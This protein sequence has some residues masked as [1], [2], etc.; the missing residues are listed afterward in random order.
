MARINLLPWR[1]EERQRKNKEFNVLAGA[2]AALSVLAI[3]LAMTFLGN[4]LSNQ[5]AAND[6]VK[7][8][9]ARLDGVLTQI[10]DLEKQR[11]DM[12]ARMKVIQDLQGHRSVPVRVWDDIARALPGNA[13]LVGMKR[14]GDM[15][16][17]TGY[18]A[19]PNVVSE[20]VRNLDASPWLASSG[21]PNVKTS[22]EAYATPSSLNQTK[23]GDLPR[24]VL[25]EDSYISFTVTTKVV[26]EGFGSE[27]T[28]DPSTNL[29]VA[30]PEGISEA[31]PMVVAPDQTQPTDTTQSD[32]NA[33]APQTQP[34]A[35]A[36]QTQPVVV[37]TQAQAA[38]AQVPP[39][40]VAPVKVEQ[41]ATTTV[42]GQAS[43]QSVGGQ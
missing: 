21:V 39:A 33:V 29:T 6:K 40:Q 27:A 17:L 5:Q 18:A 31:Q 23:E 36:P 37:E 16:T 12:L 19:D 32:Q 8:E 14:E 22:V 2:A 20:L 24:I 9:V 28:A 30:A 7:A 42:P 10:D 38:P 4:E 41:P 43:T 13:Y 26:T 34:V 1:Q 35:V 15:I 11:D 25:P 3:L